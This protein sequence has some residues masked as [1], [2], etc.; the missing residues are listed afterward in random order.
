MPPL[1][2]KTDSSSEIDAALEWHGGDARATIETL[3]LDC[4][5]LRAQLSIASRHL[6]HGLTRGWLPT[7]ERDTDALPDPS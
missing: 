6:S 5:H 1:E 7:L 2:M 4:E 3:L